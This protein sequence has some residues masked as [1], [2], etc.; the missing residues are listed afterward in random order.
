MPPI[1][2]SMLFH[3]EWMLY[4]NSPALPKVARN[5][6][7]LVVKQLVC[8]VLCVVVYKLSFIPYDR[9]TM[10]CDLSELLCLQVK[11]PGAEAAALRHDALRTWQSDTSCCPWK[12]IQFGGLKPERFR[13]LAAFLYP[14]VKACGRADSVAMA[15][16]YTRLHDFYLQM[17]DLQPPAPH[18][19]SYDFKHIEVTAQCVV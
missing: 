8:D 19:Y 16:E 5:S 3:E 13:P 7:R 17:H 6:A 2:V 4:V 15:R 1:F 9:W 12:Q 11:K 14:S 18:Y 10:L